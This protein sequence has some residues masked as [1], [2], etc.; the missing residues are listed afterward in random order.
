MRRVPGEHADDLTP[1]AGDLA[2]H[3]GDDDL[4]SHA[5]A[6]TPHAGDLAPHGG[7]LAPHGGA[8]P[9]SWDGVTGARGGAAGPAVGAPARQRSL[10]AH[11]LALAF[12]HIMFAERPI[13]R[14]ELAD[15]TGLTRPTITRIVEELLAG[16]LIAESGPARS[17]G[18]GRPRVGLTLSS[19]GPAGLGLDIRAD[20]LAACLV[21]LTGTV[22][23]LAFR[24]VPHVDGPAADLL[25]ALS[26]LAAAVMA[27]AEAAQL[28]VV[29]V[30]LAVPG[31]VSHGSLVR[32]APPLGW[33][34]VDAG[35]LL[36]TRLTTAARPA[37][38]A[39]AAAGP[40]TTAPHTTAAH[41]A[42]AHEAVPH[43]AAAH[44]AAGTESVAPSDGRVRGGASAIGGVPVRVENEANLAALAELYSGERADF[45]YVS[46]ALDLGA[47][48]VL[49]GRL[50]HGARGWSGA[51]GHVTVHPDGRDCTC[52]ARGCLQTYAGL[53]VLRA[54]AGHRDLLAAADAGTPEM[55]AALNAA[56][57]AL[58]IALADLVNLVDVGTILLGGSYAVLA[59][60]L[61]EPITTELHRRALSSR[62]APIDV[63]PAQL[64]PD[65]AA[66][67]AALTSLEAVR[68][69][70][71]SWLNR[72]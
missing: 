44:E 4:A 67:G 51:I 42:A 26:E 17:Q 28:E 6:P 30:T 53:E 25:G 13:S 22:R 9:A 14:I 1:P 8:G 12:R 62:W 68:R 72:R 21:D 23:H 36:G 43:A 32:F 59:S 37:T 61:T 60:W 20:R 18:A 19:R 15:Q 65:A 16:R 48:I 57:T 7:A 31:A 55:T 45:A 34:D 38:T 49:G 10:R 71:S 63:R 27:E 54:A 64:G 50:L 5:G 3:A 66:I 40:Q 70:P 46:G 24:P 58:G 39:S 35:A 69:D 52:G 2:P 47:G 33:R 41:P 29:R 56:G 11:N